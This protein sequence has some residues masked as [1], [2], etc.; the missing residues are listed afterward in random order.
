MMKKRLIIITKR[1]L[2]NP[3]VQLIL[4]VCGFLCLFILG[5]IFGYM[6]AML[7]GWSLR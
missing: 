6:I 2:L 5:L 4:A 7:K 1:F 3:F